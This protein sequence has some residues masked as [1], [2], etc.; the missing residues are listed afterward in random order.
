MPPRYN[1]RSRRNVSPPPQVRRRNVAPI[2]QP[3]ARSFSPQR[4]RLL[5]PHQPQPGSR[6]LPFAVPQ[7]PSFASSRRRPALSQPEPEQDEKEEKKRDR[8]RSRSRSRSPDSQRFYNQAVDADRQRRL[9]LDQQWREEEHKY[10]GSRTGPRF[11]IEEDQNALNRQFMIFNVEY[12]SVREVYIDLTLYLIRLKATL[13][14]QL[15]GLW[16]EHGGINWSLAVNMHYVHPTTGYVRAT[17]I[18]S[19]YQTLLTLRDIHT[20]VNIAFAELE[21][22]NSE[23]QEGESGWAIDHIDE[24]GKLYV[25]ATSLS[26][27]VAGGGRAPAHLAHGRGG[28]YLPLPKWVAEKQ[29]VI[30]VKNNNDQ[31]FKYA[32]ECAWMFKQNGTMPR[33][34]Q[35]PTKY[36]GLNHFEY[37]DLV[38]PIHTTDLDKFEKLNSDKK[39]SINVIYVGK[40]EGSVQIVRHGSHYALEDSWVVNL[41]ILTNSS[42]YDTQ[43]KSHWCFITHIEWMIRT[44]QARTDH[45]RILCQRCFKDFNSQASHDKHITAC[46]QH[47]AQVEILPPAHEA[48]TYFRDPTKAVQKPFVIYADSEA[49]NRVIEREAKQ[50]EANT[51]KLTHHIPASFGFMVI[52][53]RKPELSFFELKTYEGSDW[54]DKDSTNVSAWFTQRLLELVHKIKLLIGKHFSHSSSPLSEADR[55]FYH[56]SENCCICNLSLKD[57]QM[58]HWST[59]ISSRYQHGELM[60]DANGEVDELDLYGIKRKLSKMYKSGVYNRKLAKEVLELNRRKDVAWK[61]WIPYSTTSSNFLGPAHRICTDNIQSYGDIPVVFHNLTG[62]DGHL[63][64]QS[65]KK[66]W[67]NNDRDNRFTAIPQAGDKFMSFSFGGLN[68]IDSVRFEKESLD[69]LSANLRK[70]GLQA[71]VH[72][73]THLPVFLESKG[74]PYT[75]EILDMLVKKGVFPYDWFDHPSKL[76][77]TQ[78]PPIECF[79]S[80]LM[81]EHCSQER[82][83]EAQKVWRICQCKTFRD[84]HDVYLFRDISLLADVFENFRSLCFSE[85]GLEPLRY[86]SLPGYS[87]DC[88]L[89]YSYIHNHHIPLDQQPFELELFH[90]GQED[91]YAFVEDSIRGGVSMTPGRYAKANHPY[92]G[93][94]HYNPQDPLSWILYFDVNNLYGWAMS[95]MLPYGQYRWLLTQDKTQEELLRMILSHAEEDPTGFI[96]EVDGEFP[97]EVHDPLAQFPPCPTNTPIPEHCISPFLKQLYTKFSTDEH[98]VKHDH[99]TPKLVCSLSPKTQYKVYY[100]SLQQ[101]VKL[102]FKVTKIHRILAF[103]QAKWLAQYVQYNTRKRAKAK[104]KFEK[105]FYKLIV[106]AIYGKFIQDNRKFTGVE[107]F[108]S[109]YQHYKE[110]WDPNITDFRIINEDFVLAN[111]QRGSINLN[112]PIIIGAV[113]LDHAKWLMYDYWY[114]KLIP[115]FGHRIK[116]IFTDTDSLCVHIQSPDVMQELKAHD[117]F[118]HFDLSDW[119]KDDSFHGASH[120]DPTTQKPVGYFNPVNMKVVGKVKEETAEHRRYIQ[121]A[122]ALRSKM[123]SLHMVDGNPQAIICGCGKA[124]CEWSKHKSTAKGIAK[125]AKMKITHEQYRACLEPN[126]DYVPEKVDMIKINSENN[127]LYLISQNKVTLSS[128]DSKVFMINAKDTLPYG[129]Y[130]ISQYMET[131]SP[132]S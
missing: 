53:H 120:I 109:D 119:P 30:N 20:A 100:K 115:I 1:L 97:D 90:R 11:I 14:R 108:F 27:G 88:M 13:I 113:I 105:D 58:K 71:F 103:S 67:F 76:D 95:Q 75:P 36:E 60:L 24:T 51:R 46:N 10:R 112:N 130:K 22:K 121:E 62:Y 5:P 80:R 26:R 128:A 21:E 129:H 16:H 126:D 132:S 54:D 9:R 107:A 110:T 3:R 52:C 44:N 125:A 91:M 29:C 96:V 23:Y 47:K 56:T 93:Q 48:F 40:D 63:V 114:Q 69:E 102:G 77:E 101:Y 72:T 116:L 41:M 50:P 34:P 98:K 106:N 79:Y 57:G 124:N 85:H 33:D 12:D 39:L 66:E 82:Y 32:M 18:S 6:R 38:F 45:P 25:R 84:Y 31:C 42:F 65:L 7:L 131:D 92:L 94:A 86:V 83:A 8:S 99:K 2:Q 28:E 55:E 15:T 123:Y 78:L 122:I 43:T 68:F 61:P 127:Q 19:R 64:I 118:Q 74:V 87:K 37:G 73:Q 81:D 117:F 111:K 4:P 70:D 17:A 59:R 49:F 35:R 104:T 89:R